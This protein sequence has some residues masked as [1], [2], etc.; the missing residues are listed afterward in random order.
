M[1]S[2]FSRVWLLALL[3][4]SATAANAALELSLGSRQSWAVLSVSIAISGLEAGIAPALSAY[5]LDLYF[6]ASRLAYLDTVVGDGQLGDELDVF[7]AGNNLISASLSQPGRLNLFELSF[8][9]PADLNALQADTFRLALVNFVVLQAGETT[10]DLTINALAD[11]DGEALSA[12][13]ASLTVAAVPLPPSLVMMATG[14]MLL[15]TRR[16]ERGR[17]P[18]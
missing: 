5:D 3:L 16:R 15:Y 4:S 17:Q 12:S 13:P 2:M 18:A 10:L 1:N 8:D 11:A 6:D 14:L 9:D 7:D